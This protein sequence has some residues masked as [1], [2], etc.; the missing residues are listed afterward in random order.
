LVYPMKSQLVRV[1]PNAVQESDIIEAH[2]PNGEIE[3]GVAMR[4]PKPLYHC[5]YRNKRR[6]MLCEHG[7]K[8][9]HVITGWAG[10]P[11]GTQFFRVVE[12][13]TD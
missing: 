1:H 6:M 12:D 7:A 8:H 2:F 10:F 13:A 3:R 4:E 5:W 11:D 9:G